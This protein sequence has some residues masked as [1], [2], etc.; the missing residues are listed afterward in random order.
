VRT[1]RRLA[2]TLLVAAAGLASPASALASPDPKPKRTPF[3]AECHT[4]VHGSRVTTSCHNPYPESD[5]VR[6]HIEC[7]RWWDPDADSRRVEVGPARTVELS[8][9]CWMEIR[10]AWV[11]H[12][13]SGT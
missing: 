7:K 3:G 4:N 9:R 8:G 13:R 10:E 1:L 12:R 11:T 2:V 6:L 5:M